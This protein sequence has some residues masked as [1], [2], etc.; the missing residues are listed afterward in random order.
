MNDTAIQLLYETPPEWAEVVLR[1][2]DAFLLDHAACER[3]ASATGI[4]F[5]CQYPDRPY[6]INEMIKHAREELQHF[7]QVYKLVMKRG[8]TLAADEKN[9]YVNAMMALV[10]TG[11]EDRLLDRLLVVGLI[12]ARGC[13]RFRLVAENIRDEDLKN[14]YTKIYESE[15][16]HHELFIRIAEEYFEK[17]VIQSR[18]NELLVRE[19]E[20]VKS[21]PHRAAV[22]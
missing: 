20:I 18:L 1:N 12:E 9:Q 3:K 16:R 15:A 2:F 8:L 10:R 17:S 4:N 14:F 13:E 22:H 6:L 5:V 7:H 11:R 21:L 19:A